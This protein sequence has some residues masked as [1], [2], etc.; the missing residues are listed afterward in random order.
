MAVL[1]N[2]DGTGKGVNTRAPRRGPV[3]VVWV[4]QGLSKSE[5]KIFHIVLSIIFAEEVF[6]FISALGVLV[7]IRKKMCRC[8][9]SQK[10]QTSNAEMKRKTSPAE[11]LDKKIWNP[12]PTIA[13][14]Y[15]YGIGWFLP[16]CFG[17]CF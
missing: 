11:L 16:A 14:H 10:L 6:P 2:R 17:P 9:D 15:H 12:R 7:P 5:E 8:A 4:H 13:G 1:Y 3:V